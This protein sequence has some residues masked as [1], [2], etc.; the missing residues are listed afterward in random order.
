MRQG[1]KKQLQAMVDLDTPVTITRKDAPD[2][3]GK[4]VEV[5]D[6]GCKLE[7][8]TMQDP[9]T[10]TSTYVEFEDMRGVAT[11]DWNYDLIS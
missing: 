10:A 7:S 11:D 3:T 9:E 5:D 2:V 4:V 6:F 1:Y 8:S